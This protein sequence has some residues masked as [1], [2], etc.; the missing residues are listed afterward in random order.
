MNF[1]DSDILASIMKNHNY[2]IVGKPDISDIVLIN[3]CSI[4]DNAEQRVRKRLREFRALRKKNPGLIIGVIGCMAERLKEQLISEEGVDIVVGPD[5]YRSLPGLLA[6]LN[7]GETAINVIL[8]DE[9]TYSDIDPERITSNGVSAFIPIMRGCTNFC[10]YCVVPFTRGKERSRN[11][12][13]IIIEAEK[14]FSEGYREVSLL[15]QNVNSYIWT[16]NNKSYDFPDLLIKVAAISPE[17]RVRFAT[18]HPKDISDKLIEVISQTPNVCKAIHLPV[19]SGSNKILKLMNR[20]YSIEWYKDRITAIKTLIPDCSISTDII[21]G[22]CGETEED[23]QETLALMEWVHYDSAFMFMYSERAGTHA[24]NH[25]I[26]NVSVLIKNE[27]LNRI[28]TLQQKLSLESNI[29]EK[30]SIQEVLIEGRSKRN[31]EF[32]S[33]RTTKN[34]VVV[35][36]R[37]DKVPGEY[38]NVLIT[39]CTA[40][41]LTGEIKQ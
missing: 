20:K 10:S 25:L 9:E 36:P 23:H 7:P 38:V 5:S 13:S 39:G 4:R 11:P 33:G 12:G 6:S 26:D 8:S 22:F 2:E 16:G 32:L 15:G 27:R 35:F 18:S 30:G 37:L 1:S 28:I 3:T 17:L 14:L 41:T 34:K 21:T 19:Q 29:K 40:A 31:A 24:A